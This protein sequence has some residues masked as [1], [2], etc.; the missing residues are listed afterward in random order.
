MLTALAL[1]AAVVVA[2]PEKASVDKEK[3]DALVAQLGGEKFA[4]REAAEKELKEYGREI[5]P[6]VR[7]HENSDDP[8]IKM[9]VGRIIEYV[10]SNPACIPQVVYVFD[11]KP[12]EPNAK[13][14]VRLEKEMKA[15]RL[16][17]AV[18]V[19]HTK[20][21]S[22]RSGAFAQS[23][24]PRCNSIKAIETGA[25]ATQSG[26]GWV[27]LDV[28]ADQGGM[29]GA[30]V[31]SRAWVRIE[32]S[33]PGRPD[34]CLVFDI[35][36]IAVEADKTYWITFSEHLDPAQD[37]G[38]LTN[39]K[40]ANNRAYA[41]G[42]YLRQGRQ[43]PYDNRDA[44]F[45]IISECESVP[46]LRK[47]TDEEKKKL[48]TANEHLWNVPNPNVIFRNNDFIIWNGP[49]GGRVILHE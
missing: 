26:S 41:D 29:P 35:P 39:H 10:R 13:V 16:K 40:Y 30:H 8:E 36:D 11:I 38:N 37:H 3:I 45:S 49:D 47:A 42:K 23:F 1:V 2:A 7:K 48:P 33:T 31:L 15:W 43:T 25:F 22:T 18:A 5:L 14:F 32:K 19:S 21:T 24:I 17:A 9:R 12:D 34:L 4:Q 46:L 20:G 44:V 6:L 27:C 28:R